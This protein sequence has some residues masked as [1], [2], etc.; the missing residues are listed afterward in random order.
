MLRNQNYHQKNQLLQK[1]E[2]HYQS[3]ECFKIQFDIEGAVQLLSNINHEMRLISE[4]GSFEVKPIDEKY[5]I[6]NN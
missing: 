5:F 3:I 2:R 1:I 4:K 6:Y